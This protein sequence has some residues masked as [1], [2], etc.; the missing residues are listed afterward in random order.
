MNKLSLASVALAV[1]ASGIIVPHALAQRTTPPPSDA[2]LV[3]DVE[4]VLQNEKAFRGLT[5]V[6]KTSRGIVTL[7]GTVSSEGD[8]VLA[9]LEVGN[10]DGVKTVINNLDVKASTSTEGHPPALAPN[11]AQTQQLATEA[12]TYPAAAAPPGVAVERTITIPANTSIQVRITD[13]LTSKTAKANDHCHGTVAA[14]VFADGALAI[15]VGTPVLGRVVS[16][17]RAGHFIAEAKMALE[18]TTLRLPLLDG[19]SRDVPVVTAYL[20]NNGQ[21]HGSNVAPSGQIEVKPQTVLRFQTQAALITSVW[22]KNG[23]QLQ[24]PAAQDPVLDS[25]PSCN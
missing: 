17:K 20:T 4:A 18:I 22:I 16:A 8:K 12:R 7:T 19:R 21:P 23:T 24:L 3:H 1:I 14:V 11:G 10:V 5:I 25:R 15:P 6:P 2:K 13:S 9:G